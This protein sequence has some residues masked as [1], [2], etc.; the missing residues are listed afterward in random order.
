ME[1]EEERDL[2]KFEDRLWRLDKESETIRYLLE[3][4]VEMSLRASNSAKQSSVYEEA[5]GR[6]LLNVKMCRFG[7][8]KA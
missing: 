3:V 5:K 6:R 2:K 7:I 1:L 4:R 8:K